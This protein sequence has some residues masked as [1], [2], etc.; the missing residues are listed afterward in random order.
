MNLS[1][2]L[3]DFYGA[4]LMRN[5]EGLDGV[6]IPIVP[7]GKEVIRKTGIKSVF[8]NLSI[9]PSTGKKNYDYIGRLVVPDKYRDLIYSNSKYAGIRQVAWGYVGFNLK[10]AKADS[11][12]DFDRITN[13][14]Q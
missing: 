14:E 8:V 6:F 9:Y 12:K 4:E 7:N 11:A 3:T 2:S 1:I 10:R 5:Q 13:K